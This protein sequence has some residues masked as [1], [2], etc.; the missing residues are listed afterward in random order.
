VSKGSFFSPNQNMTGHTGDESLHTITCIGNEEQKQ[1]TKKHKNQ[2]E[3]NAMT[4]NIKMK[5]V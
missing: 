1:H 5:K 3:T 2:P 4:Q